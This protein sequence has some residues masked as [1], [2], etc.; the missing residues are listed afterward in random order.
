MQRNQRDWSRFKQHCFHHLLSSQA[1]SLDLQRT[2]KRNAFTTSFC[3]TY[4]QQQTFCCLVNRI[5]C[6]HFAKIVPWIWFFIACWLSWYLDGLIVVSLV[7]Y[8]C[9]RNGCQESINARV[10]SINCVFRQGWNLCIIFLTNKTAEKS[11]E[12]I[13]C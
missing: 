4:A 1:L 10:S 11:F 9:S 2:H 6:K 7:T 12:V 8:Q 13:S 3:L 5:K